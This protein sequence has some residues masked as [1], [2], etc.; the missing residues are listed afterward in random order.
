MRHIQLLLV[1]RVWPRIVYWILNG[2]YQQ[3]IREFL[4]LRARTASY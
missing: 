1:V 3:L 2:P 4:V